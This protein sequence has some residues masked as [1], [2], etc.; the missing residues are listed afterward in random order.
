MPAYANPD[1]L[2]ST[3]WLQNNLSRPDVRV[4][5]ASYWA[6]IEQRDAWEEFLELHVPGAAF[7]DIDRICDAASPEDHMLPTADVFAAEVGKLGIGND[8]HV[9]VYDNAGGGAAA[10]RVWWMFHVFGHRRVSVVDGGFSAWLREQRPTEEGEASPV[11]RSFT[12]HW[13]G[14]LTRT[15]DQ[16]EAGL[17]REQILDARSP[18]RFNGE[19]P[20]PRPTPRLGHIPG[21]INVPFLDLLDKREMTFLPADRLR[22]RFEAAGVDL[23]RPVVATCGSGVT[24][25]LLTLGLYLIGKTDFANYDGS[26]AEWSQHPE[27]PIETGTAAPLSG[28]RHVA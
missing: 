22:R 15:L 26:W 4:L 18:A 28:A 8:S 25:C 16:V 17:G 2:V 7:F 1:A 19:A 3:D 20:E 9:V 13:N 5:D 23:D 14:A 27:L 10:A 11:P 24:C 12:P 21:S 6:R